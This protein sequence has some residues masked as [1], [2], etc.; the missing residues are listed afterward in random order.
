MQK[1][2]IVT[3]TAE[4]LGTQG[5]GI[6]RCEGVTLFVPCL[7]PG[8]RAKVKILRVKENIAYGKVTELIIPAEERVRPVCPV[9]LRCGGCQLQHIRYRDQLKF[10][11]T[12]VRD[13]LKK[14]GG[15]TAEVRPAERSE[16][17]Y[18][19]RNKLSIPV[20]KVNGH[21]AVGFYAEH[22]HRIIET[23]ECPIHPEWSKD[24]IAALL[25]FMEK[26]GLDGYDETTKK[27]Q[28]RHIVVR[29]I[30]G[31][32]LITLVVTVH[33]IKG[34]DYFVYLLGQIF[35][36]F[37][38]FL[39]FNDSD[40]NVVMGGEFALVHGKGVYEGTDMGIAYEAGAS[41]FVQVNDGVRGKLYERAVSLVEGGVVHPVHG[42]D[43]GLGGG[44]AFA[45]FRKLQDL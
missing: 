20:G 37:S 1:N 11:T 5:E 33:E 39:N 18:G 43:L 31:K 34:I 28:I 44:V 45:L 38:L 13:T 4:G 26:C 21:N 16:R 41:T 23:T 2:S 27:G 17:E 14:I 19:Y 15:I 32:F 3:V 40:T 36:E 25:G 35:H 7:L 30:K 24:L 12:L 42:V 29:E 22:S 10:K 8:E 6:A 9:F